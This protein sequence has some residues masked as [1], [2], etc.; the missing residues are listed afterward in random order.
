M[1]GYIEQRFKQLRNL[2]KEI[3]NHDTNCEFGLIT[4]RGSFY[5]NI[6][7]EIQSLAALKFLPRVDHLIPIDEVH[8]F[9]SPRGRPVKVILNGYFTCVPDAWPPSDHIDPLIISFHLSDQSYPDGPVAGPNRGRPATVVLPHGDGLNFFKKAKYLGCRDLVTVEHLAS[10]GLNSA[11]FSGCLTLTLDCSWAYRS[12]K[13]Y[14]VDVNYDTRLILESL[15]VEM[16][17]RVEFVTHNLQDAEDMGPEARF[18]K[19]QEL[20]YKYKTAELVITSRLHCAL[21]CLALGTPCIFVMPHHDL[22][23]LPG[24][25]DLLNCVD[26]EEITSRGLGLDG[27]KPLE[28]PRKHLHLRAALEEKCKAFIHGSEGGEG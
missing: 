4:Y 24:L 2:A 28:N 12:G 16:R 15:P 10:V 19:A 9:R 6:G 20:V 26:P 7:D 1:I 27:N 25:T 8:T 11:F 14:V 23:R 18:S 5:N 3:P 13:V 17:A 21:P 22:S